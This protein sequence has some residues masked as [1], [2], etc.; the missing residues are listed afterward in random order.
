MGSGP[1]PGRAPPPTCHDMSPPQ[2]PP[3]SFLLCSSLP[4]QH[5][6][7]QRMSTR[8]ILMTAAASTTVRNRLIGQVDKPTVLLSQPVL[9]SLRHLLPPPLCAGTAVSVPAGSPRFRTAS[10][11]QHGSED[12]STL[13]SL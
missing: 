13:L 12:T 10:G 11:S 5:R 8:M 3:Q 4:P 1:D 6:A 2:P 9:Q 7:V